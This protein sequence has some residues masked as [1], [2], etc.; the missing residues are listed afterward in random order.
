MKT[1]LVRY[2]LGGRE[3]GDS[4]GSLGNGVLGKLS[5]QHKSDRGLDFSGRKGGLLVVLGELSSLTGD[6][7]EDVVDEGVHDG[8]TFLGDSGIRVDLFQ[9]L[10]DVGRVTL[11]SLALSLGAGGLLWGL[12]GFLAWSLSHFE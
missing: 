12:G 5:R 1:L 2:L 7:L 4:L 10:V 11:G 6:S 9:D 8:H 3:F